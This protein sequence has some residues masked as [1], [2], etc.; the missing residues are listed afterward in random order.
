MTKQNFGLVGGAN[1]QLVKRFLPG[2]IRQTE[3]IAKDKLLADRD[4][5]V[6]MEVSDSATAVEVPISDVM[7]EC[8][9]QVAQDEAFYV[10]PKREEAGL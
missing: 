10:E 2:Y 6:V 5:K 9:I 4:G 1:E 8:G 7:I 3:E